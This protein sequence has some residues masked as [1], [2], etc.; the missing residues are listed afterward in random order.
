M[1]M[2]LYPEVIGSPEVVG[3][4]KE[5]GKRSQLMYY[6]EYPAN[7]YFAGYHWGN[8]EE[9]PLARIALHLSRSINEHVLESDLNQ[10][11]SSPFAHRTLIFVKVLRT[12]ENGR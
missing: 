2:Q 12:A 10:L 11:P 3:L 5:I 9:W 7:P 8:A 6:F 4:A 1:L